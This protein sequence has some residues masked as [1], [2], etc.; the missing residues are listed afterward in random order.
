MARY[1]QKFIRLYRPATEARSYHF[2]NIL[3]SFQSCWKTSH[4]ATGQVG[5]KERECNRVVKIPC[6]SERRRTTRHKLQSCG[7]PTKGWNFLGAL[8]AKL[9]EL[10][11]KQFTK[12]QLGRPRIQRANFSLGRKSME[13]CNF[14]G[15]TAPVPSLRS[16]QPNVRCVSRTKRWTW[17]NEKCTDVTRQKI[18]ITKTDE[19]C[20]ELRLISKENEISA[21][22]RISACFAL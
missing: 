20:N 14:F 7:T 17:T 21:R 1:W 19:G 16:I 9:G 6:G 22:R 15:L 10:L 5:G 13:E 8:T 18:R 4:K 2:E 11:S 3:T 12:P